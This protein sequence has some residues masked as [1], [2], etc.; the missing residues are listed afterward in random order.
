MITYRHNTHRV[1]FKCI[2]SSFNCFSGLSILFIL[3][4]DHHVSSHWKVITCDQVCVTVSCTPS[5]RLKEQKRSVTPHFAPLSVHTA[6]PSVLTSA[7]ASC[8]CSLQKN[9]PCRFVKLKRCVL[10]CYFPELEWPIY[11]MVSITALVETFLPYVCA[12]L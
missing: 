2:V 9:P 4:C 12:K 10:T 11:K 3:V 8:E 7:K 5:L 6:F 1:F